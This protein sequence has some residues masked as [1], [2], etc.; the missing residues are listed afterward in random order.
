VNSDPYV[1]VV[2]AT[3][4]RAHFLADALGSLLVQQKAPRFEAI[5]VDNGSRDA[6]QDVLATF[7]ARGDIDVRSAFVAEPNRGAARNAGIALARGVIVLFVDDDVVLPPGFLAAHTAAHAGTFPVAVSGPILNV[8][9]THHRPEPGAANYSRAFFCT[10]NVSVPRSALVAAGNFDERFNLYGWE[11]TE[12]GLRL[13]RRDVRRVFSWDAY[14]WHIK[15]QQS[16]TLEVLL[17]K[18]TQRAQMAARLLQ[19]HDG[20]RA[21]LATGA[22]ALNLARAAI[23]SPGWSLPFFVRLASDGTKPAMVRAF[24]RAQAL[25]VAYTTTLRRALAAT[26]VPVAESAR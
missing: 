22:Y 3:K 10:C 17:D 7:A 6:T 20:W 12:L 23:F 16:E 14:L 18:V 11:D 8:P 13:R 5:V 2:I 25:D 15:P 21:R 9:D 24:A 4:D 1:S 26:T 19:K